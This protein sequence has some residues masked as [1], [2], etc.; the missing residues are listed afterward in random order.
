MKINMSLAEGKDM[1]LKLLNRH[2]DEAKDLGRK[3]QL[4]L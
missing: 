4:T 1:G 3:K 2:K